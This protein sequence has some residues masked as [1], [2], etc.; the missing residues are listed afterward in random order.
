MRNYGEQLQTKLDKLERMEYEATVNE[1]RNAPKKKPNVDIKFITSSTE[2]SE[3]TDDGMF[4]TTLVQIAILNRC[5]VIFYSSVRV[6]RLGE[7]FEVCHN[8][9][10]KNVLDSI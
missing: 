7:A 6:I 9:D 2:I 10:V 4:R 5:L 1:L 3:I 8:N